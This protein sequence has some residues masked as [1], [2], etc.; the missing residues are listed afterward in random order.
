MLR[1]ESE[2]KEYEREADSSMAMLVL[3]LISGVVFLF[4]IFWL[5]RVL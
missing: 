4:L 5:G 1:S 3:C 2:R